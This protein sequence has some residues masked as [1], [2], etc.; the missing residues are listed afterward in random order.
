[1][2][3]KKFKNKVAYFFNILMIIK[4]HKTLVLFKLNLFIMQYKN[5]NIMNLLNKEHIY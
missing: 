2:L 4:K 5:N 3:F 1:M